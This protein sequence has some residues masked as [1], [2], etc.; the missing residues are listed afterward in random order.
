MWY[1][2][3]I[4]EYDISSANINILRQAKAI[5]D[6]IYY[7]LVDAPK[8]SRNILIGKMMRD[9]KELVQVVE[10][11]CRKSINM[12]IKYNNI[13][14]S[15]ILEIAKDALWLYNCEPKD[16]ILTDNITFVK[17]RAYQGMILVSDKI[18]IYVK[19][20]KLAIRGDK[21]NEGYEDEPLTQFIHTV[22]HKL[23][24]NSGKSQISRL[25][26]LTKKE[27]KNQYLKNTP[28]EALF[29]ALKNILS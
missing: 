19:N 1:I 21:F 28:N 6:D 4:A 25:F 8:L 26:T 2:G 15:A 5:T 17:K 12:L 29:K 23:S 24:T 27:Q 22:Q 3:T 11:G 13:P 18:K 14:Q 9:N 20:G 10:S 7:S 16:L